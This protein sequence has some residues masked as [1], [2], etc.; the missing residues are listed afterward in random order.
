[1]C[2]AVVRV[3]CS[4]QLQVSAPC[5]VMSPMDSFCAFLVCVASAM[6]LYRLAC[7]LQCLH[8]FCRVCIVCCW[9]IVGVLL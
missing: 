2:L 8:V 5:F 6:K 4:C 7:L 1:V 9:Y 3:C